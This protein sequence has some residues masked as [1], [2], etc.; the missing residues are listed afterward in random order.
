MAVHERVIGG[1]RKE[2]DGFRKGSVVS[3]GAGWFQKR[4]SEAVWVHGSVY[5]FRKGGAGWFQERLG[6]FSRGWGGS[7]K[8]CVVS[9]KAAVSGQAVGLHE[10]VC[11]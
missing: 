6:G 4:L 7:R 3:G 10:S 2:L 1:F 8:S 9:G 5:E 11:I